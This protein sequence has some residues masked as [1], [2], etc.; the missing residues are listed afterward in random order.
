MGEA[1]FICHGRTFDSH[2]GVGD[3]LPFGKTVKRCC[4]ALASFHVAITVLIVRFLLV[5]ECYTFISNSAV[6]LSSPMFIQID[7]I[8]YVVYYHILSYVSLLSSRYLNMH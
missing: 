1:L 3:H 2:C 7:N 6:P 8:F 5:R 4:S